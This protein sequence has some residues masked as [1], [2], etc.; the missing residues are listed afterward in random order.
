MPEGSRGPSLSRSPTRPA[1]ANTTGGQNALALDS[2][3][4]MLEVQDALE[5]EVA[6][7][8]G[9]VR[10][11]EEHLRRLEAGQLDHLQV[12]STPAAPGAIRELVE[13][14][15]QAREVALV[16]LR[17]D[18]AQLAQET[19]MA[20]NTLL[21]TLQTQEAQWQGEL[22]I[23]STEL[24][25]LAANLRASL[26]DLRSEVSQVSIDNQAKCS[27]LRDLV[28]QVQTS[29]FESQAA[30]TLTREDLLSLEDRL[31]AEVPRAVESGDA[32]CREELTALERK[33]G[34]EIM[35]VVGQDLQDL[36]QRL[37]AEVSS[38]LV[39]SA[40]FSPED[41]S[42]L[43]Y[44]LREEVPALCD[45]GMF[46]T[47]EDLTTL[48]GDVGAIERMQVEVLAASA[49]GKHLEAQLEELQEQ[50][51]QEREAR[52]S[53]VNEVLA[54]L[55]D[56][57]GSLRA[58][59]DGTSLRG[60]PEGTACD[61]VVLDE[62][63]SNTQELVR[64]VCEEQGKLSYALDQLRAAFDEHATG[65]QS[66]LKGEK[67]QRQEQ[68]D[69][70]GRAV[71]EL[72]AGFAAS[73]AQLNAR[74]AAQAASYAQCSDEALAGLEGRLRTSLAKEVGLMRGEASGELL[75][76]CKSCL[77][78]SGDQSP[79]VRQHLLQYL[80]A[81][82]EQLRG[83][84]SRGF[85]AHDV[86]YKALRD[87]I[88]SHQA[89]RDSA[90]ITRQHAAVPPLALPGIEAGAE[91]RLKSELA[92]VR[93]WRQCALQVAMDDLD[94]KQQRNVTRAFQ[95]FRDKIALTPISCA[96]SRSTLPSAHVSGNVMLDSPRR[97]SPS[98]THPLQ[99]GG[100]SVNVL[101]ESPRSPRARLRVT[102]PTSTFSLNIHPQKAPSGPPSARATVQMGA[103]SSRLAQQRVQ[104]PAGSP[105]KSVGLTMSPRVAGSFRAPLSR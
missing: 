100:S 43:E 102:S 77:L 14:E 12:T 47:Q 87:L 94:A 20:S 53:H 51:G 93:E 23:L 39:G 80:E 66:Q 71:E 73:V 104:S 45:T 37:R 19:V 64:G 31:R 26:H 91:Q 17:E 9:A 75:D 69:S 36:E 65:C 78:P 34:D 61:K 22:S 55:A 41:L 67:Q 84:V 49:A 56:I 99:C 35:A 76:K 103:L 18:H 6:E 8:Q 3:R 88:T 28:D 83:D 57:E 58:S 4:L 97:R 27:G 5:R 50:L 33:I 30:H 21:S 24:Q 85:E 25:H 86:G 38:P 15:Q 10:R 59:G 74:L 16:V 7:R 96:S 105:Q 40:A 90:R 72:S 52:E 54:A 95:D 101:L 81:L 42:A 68:D 70:L 2:A 79:A 46:A 82:D 89:S 60:A 92:Q 29:Q 13:Q 98:P 44:R 1:S 63:R 62:E 32:V 48:A 11:L